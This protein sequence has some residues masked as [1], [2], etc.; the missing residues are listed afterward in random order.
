M[1]VDTKDTVK[2]MV[3]SEND[4][5]VRFEPLDFR[6]LWVLHPRL[7]TSLHAQIQFRAFTGRRQG[8]ERV[9]LTF[10]A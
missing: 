9:G 2:L 4:A 5:S 7:L 8:D 6:R 3:F 1:T 10:H